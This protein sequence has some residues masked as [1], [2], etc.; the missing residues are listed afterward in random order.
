MV[1]RI[2]SMVAPQVLG[3]KVYGAFYPPLVM[4]VIPLLGALLVLYL[5][6]TRG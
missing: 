1:A 4:G 6:E 5:P 2:G 3:L